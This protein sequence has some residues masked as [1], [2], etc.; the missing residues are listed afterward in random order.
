MIKNKKTKNDISVEYIPH[1]N[2]IDESCN[3]NELI[4]TTITT[5]PSC[6]NNQK[7]NQ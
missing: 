6:K 4:E 3:E 1:Y 2:P 5:K 7:N